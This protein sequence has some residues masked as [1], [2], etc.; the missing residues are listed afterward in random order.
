[1]TAFQ[2]NDDPEL[3]WC[4]DHK[5]YHPANHFAKREV[6]KNSYQPRCLQAA[7]ERIAKWKTKKK[8]NELKT[9][10]QLLLFEVS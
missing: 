2:M 3:V 4:F 1:M 5:E 10:G 8:V 7:N 6:S 9:N